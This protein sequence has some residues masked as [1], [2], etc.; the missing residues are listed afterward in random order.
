[1]KP[2]RP[3]SVNGIEPPPLLSAPPVQ[4]A[5]CR[6]TFGGLSSVQGFSVYARCTKIGV[7]IASLSLIID[8]ALCFRRRQIRY[9]AAMKQL[10]SSLIS[11][12][13]SSKRTEKG[14][15]LPHYLKFYKSMFQPCD[16]KSFRNHQSFRKL[17]PEWRPRPSKLR[18]ADTNTDWDSKEIGFIN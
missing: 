9:E 5:K 2:A 13:S 12:L 1:M 8:L 4:Q 18:P 10:L 6:G 7:D 3:V 11:D 16:D 14:S 15:I 17:C